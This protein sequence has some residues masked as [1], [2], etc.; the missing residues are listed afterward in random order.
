MS[1]EE[2]TS[3]WEDLHSHV[4]A[5]S[6]QAFV[7][8]FLQR[9]LRA[10]IEH[11]SGEGTGST[12]ATLDLSRLLPRYKHSDRRLILLDFEGTFWLNRDPRTTE[13]NPPKEALD[14]VRA[15]ADD[16]RNEV[17]LLSGL[18]IKGMLEKLAETLPNVGLV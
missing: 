8:T 13:F 6:A 18:P 4:V 11:L 16:M 5:Q 12:V 10:N 2:A 3:R 15:L 9:C 7:T 17:W 1:D 14:A